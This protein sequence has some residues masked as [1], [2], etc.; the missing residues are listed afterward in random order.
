MYDIAQKVEEELQRGKARTLVHEMRDFHDWFHVERVLD[1]T[2]HDA[3]DAGAEQE[4]FEGFRD[5][6]NAPL[7]QTPSY[8]DADAGRNTKGHL[9]MKSAKSRRNMSLHGRG[10]DANLPRRTCAMHSLFS[11][12]CSIMSTIGK[13]MAPRSRSTPASPK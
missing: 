3:Y 1:A 9:S 8:L 4:F 5:R 10:K 12:A 7:S 2:E 6:S 11:I 13:Q